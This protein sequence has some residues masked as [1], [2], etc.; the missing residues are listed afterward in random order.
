[1]RSKAGVMVMSRDFTAPTTG[2]QLNIAV[3]DF[4]DVS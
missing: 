4:M 3:A 2:W 1:M